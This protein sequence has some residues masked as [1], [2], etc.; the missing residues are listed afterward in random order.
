[1]TQLLTSHEFLP[2]WNSLVEFEDEKSEDAEMLRALERE[3][4]YQLSREFNAAI[5]AA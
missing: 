3:L 4:L 1:M 2:C 5:I